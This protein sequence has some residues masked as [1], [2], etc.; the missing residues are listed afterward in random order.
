MDLLT[1]LS[2]QGGLLGTLLAISLL[3]NWWLLKSLLGEK[4]KR[5]VGAE[6]V[7][8]DLSTPIAYIRDSLDLIQQ[9]IRVSK[10]AEQS[11]E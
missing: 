1:T 4:D 7:R 9:K 6:K 10:K 2:N 5:I 3:A 11:D 8:D